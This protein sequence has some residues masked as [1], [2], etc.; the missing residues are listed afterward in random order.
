MNLKTIGLAVLL[1]LLF[2]A[3]AGKAV[4]NL[5]EAAFSAGEQ[6]A[7]LTAEKEACANNYENLMKELETIKAELAV[8]EQ[9]RLDLI[10]DVNASAETI[11]ALTRARNDLRN[12]VAGL[13][14]SVP[15]TCTAQINWLR[16]EAIKDR[17]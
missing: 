1:G 17:P 14:A 11:A 4:Y 15:T 3:L 5:Y 8:L 9:Q 13:V 12:R 7:T 16:E 10:K 6:V 2:L